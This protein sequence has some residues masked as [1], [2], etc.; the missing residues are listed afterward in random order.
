MKRFEF[1]WS[2]LL[3][4]M[5]LAGA[6]AWTAAAPARPSAAPGTEAASRALPRCQPVL[7]A[8]EFKIGRVF[9]ADCVP[10]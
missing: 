5:I 10:N 2:V 4:A 1:A 7:P 8:Y 6:V 9:P 3:S